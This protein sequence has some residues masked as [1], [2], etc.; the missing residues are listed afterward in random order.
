MIK[1]E[2]ELNHNILKTTMMIQ[3]TYP[4]LSKY[5]GEMPVRISDSNDATTTIKNLQDYSDSL[6]ALLKKYAKDHV[7][8]I[9]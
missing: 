7:S 8:A 5:I 6:D 3:E 4:E 2:K 9:K 1:T